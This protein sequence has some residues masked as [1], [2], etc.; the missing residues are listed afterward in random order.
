MSYVLVACRAKR[1]VLT[2]Q[3]ISILSYGGTVLLAVL[4]FLEPME[5]CMQQH[6]KP[7]RSMGGLMKL[8][9]CMA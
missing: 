7:G 1:L 9:N 8:D 6:E 5:V 2:S 4:L 3:V